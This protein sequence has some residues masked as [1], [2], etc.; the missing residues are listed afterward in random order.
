MLSLLLYPENKN[1]E[2]LDY[3]VITSAYGRRK[4]NVQNLINSSEIYYV[5]ENKER[6]ENWLKALE[7]QL[8]SAL[9]K[10]GP[11]KSIPQKS[12]VDNSFDENSSKNV[13]EGS[14]SSTAFSVAF[15]IFASALAF[16]LSQYALS[17]F[18]SAALDPSSTFLPCS[19]FK[20]SSTASLFAFFCT[21]VK[22]L[23]GM[24]FIKLLSEGLFF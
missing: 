6:T 3:A 24:Y 1:G 7:L 4:N 23:S 13:D 19:F 9:T 21:S 20:S 16:T 11:I 15:C 22:N 12:E 14:S 8:P 10:F 2:I 17:D 5:D 18:F